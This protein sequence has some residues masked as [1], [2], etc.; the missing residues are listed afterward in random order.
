MIL[1]TWPSSSGWVLGTLGGAATVKNAKGEN[2]HR[3]GEMTMERQS[4]NMI[5]AHAGP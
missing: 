5:K 1:R 3:R 4:E 2:Q